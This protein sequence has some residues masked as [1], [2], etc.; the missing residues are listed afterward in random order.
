MIDIDGEKLRT[1][2]EWEKAHRHVL[3]RERGKGVT[4]EWRSPHGKAAATWYRLDQT[5]PWTEVE[6]TR[7]KRQRAAARLDAKLAE[8]RAEAAATQRRRDLAEAQGAPSGEAVDIWA[9]AWQWVSRGF[10][11]IRGAR[12][13]FGDGGEHG[14]S[15]DYYYC[16]PW[17]VRFDPGLAAE[18]LDTGPREVDRLP[19]GRPYTGRPWWN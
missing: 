2:R 13:A 3:A 5:R 16:S 8:A 4:K 9:T 6:M 19:D 11:P 12:W 18:L 1:A 14:A 15:A 10:V 7:L 17:H